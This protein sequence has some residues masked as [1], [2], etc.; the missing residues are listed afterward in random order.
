[1]S[2]TPAR[3]VSR[4]RGP[5]PRVAPA[6]PAAP[7][8]PSAVA[9]TAP[10]AAPAATPAPTAVA[11]ERRPSAR[12]RLLDAA[13]RVIREKG[14]S[15]TT[16]DDLCA[17]AGVTKGA[18]FHHFR[19]KED[20]AV[21]AAAH[22]SAVTSALFAAAPYHAPEDPLDRVL[23]YL[24]FRAALVRGTAA[25]FTCL[26]GTM[27]QETFATAPAIRD[28]CHASIAGHAATLEPDFAA[29]IDRYGAPADVDAKSLAL[30]T[31]TVLQG[32]F[33]LAKAANDAAMVLDA[34]A[35]LR[36]YLELLF[37][38]PSARTR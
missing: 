4:Q 6:A 31:Q 9:V 19:S 13:L 37:P 12:D 36:R 8:V 1:M 20:L 34:I 18:F 32:A 16:V 22:W 7:A 2:E 14:Y 25:E 28:A 3:Y 21:A 30:H 11:A 24:E 23:A 35:H 10:G 15:A 17:G 26:A 29:A 33:V 27:A 38:R 5:A